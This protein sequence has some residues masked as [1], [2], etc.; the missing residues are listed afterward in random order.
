MKNIS[1]H[2]EELVWKFLDQEITE[3]EFVELEQ[4]LKSDAGHRKQYQHLVEVHLSLK[5]HAQYPEGKSGTATPLVLQHTDPVQ[6]GRG[7]E[8]SITW[9]A[10]IAAVICF[11]LFV[12]TLLNKAPSLGVE[13]IA[14][15]DADIRGA[16]IAVGDKANSQMTHLASGAVALKFPSNTQAIIEGPAFYQ[17]QS[18]GSIKVSSGTIT[19]DHQGDPGTFKVLT[20]L[21]ELVDMGTKFGVKIGNGVTDSMVMTEVYEGEVIYQGDRQ[22]PLSMTEGNAFAILGNNSSKDIVT[23]IDG[24]SVR[25]SGTFD[26]SKNETDLKRIENLALGKPVTA[27]SYYN[28]PKS[29]QVFPASALTDNRLADSGSPWDWSFWLAKN[30]DPGSVI[31]D[32][33]EV[34]NISRVEM[35]NTRNRQYFDRG[36]KDYIIEV[37]TDDEH[38]TQ[39]AS[40][41]LERVPWHDPNYF[42]FESVEFESTPA[43]Y[44]RI[45][46]LTN[47]TPDDKRH[48]GS[49]GLNEVRVFE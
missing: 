26:L 43:R 41:S 16:S 30:G 29:G 11:G 48:T 19:V 14:V 15:R 8:R 18:N 6:R 38:Y 2:F 36:I 27:S 44:V 49:G 32:L 33:L 7:I 9:F 5:N 17:V 3:K 23:E 10:G 35:Q 24:E 45:T 4:L 28:V 12:F 13:Y 25:V 34:Y 31:I 39:V 1:S 22:A 40:G 20:P 37:S 21:G 46:G 47:H 42:K